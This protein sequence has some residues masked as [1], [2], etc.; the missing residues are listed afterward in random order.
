MKYFVSYKYYSKKQTGFGSIEYTAKKV[1][2]T[3]EEVLTLLE[4]LNIIIQDKYCRQAECAILNY[5]PLPGN[6]KPEKR[7]MFCLHCGEEE[8]YI[9]TETNPEELQKFVDKAIAHEQSC[10]GNPLVLEI[11]ELKQ[12]VASKD[13]EYD[14]FVINTNEKHR[15]TRN[16]RLELEKQIRDLGRELKNKPKND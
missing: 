16:K 10:V 15:R 9:P 14:D 1:I 8:V 13:K 11:A 12:K 2:D 4:W 6:S 5:I 7:S 3:Y